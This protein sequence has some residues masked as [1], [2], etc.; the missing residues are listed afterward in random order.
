[1]RM[2]LQPAKVLSGV[3]Q[4]FL[5]MRQEERERNWLKRQ[6]EIERRR[7]EQADHIKHALVVLEAARKSQA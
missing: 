2:T 5:A 4:G 7:I 3:W 6:D 1:M